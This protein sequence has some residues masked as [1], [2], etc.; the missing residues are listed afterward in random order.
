[1]GGKSDAMRLGQ[2]WKPEFLSRALDMDMVA[3]NFLANG[4]RREKEP[5]HCRAMATG[6]S[7]GNAISGVWRTPAARIGAAP[8]LPR[9][10]RQ[11]NR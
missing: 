3:A 11:R 2:V 4:R 6:G 9:R 5:V 8:G 7:G 1:M 10:R